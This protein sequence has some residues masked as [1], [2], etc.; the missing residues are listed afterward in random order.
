M[1]GVLVHGTGHWVNGQPCVARRIAVAEAVGVGG[2]LA[3]GSTIVLTGASRYL[4][5]PAI[6]LTIGG[7]GLFVTSFAADLY[8]ATGA[9]RFAGEPERQRPRWEAE[10]GLLR[11][12]N[13]LFDFEWL[14]SQQWAANVAMLR[15]EGALD[16]AFD[17]TH[18]RY[19]LGATWRA[20]GPRSDR[21]YRD[22]SYLDLHTGVTE[23][24]YVFSGFVTDSVELSATGRLD[25]ARL[26]PTLRGSF[27]ELS[28]GVALARTRYAIDGVSVP[29]DLESLLLGRIAFGAYLGRGIH[30]GSEAMF[31]Y[32]HRHDDYAAGMK[33]PGLGG[34]TL[35]HVGLSLRYFF[36]RHLG[37]GST[38]QAGSAYVAGVSLLF[39]NGGQP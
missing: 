39:R 25:L 5:L 34:G 11:V 31:F 26:G 16:T 6:S 30:R 33:V 22:G 13:P 10:L 35:G 19:R 8:G 38:L 4:M 14:A 20:F 36:N 1:P 3:G 37:V 12:K 23:Q 18:A 17:A 24:R 32:D 28:T 27:A 7:F 9:A 2:V 15:F 29:A 21:M